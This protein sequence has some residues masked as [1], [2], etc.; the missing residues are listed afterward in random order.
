MSHLKGRGDGGAGEPGRVRAPA[1]GRRN[2]AD[3]QWMQKDTRRAEETRGRLAT[4]LLPGG[5]GAPPSGR[6]AIRV[7]SL[8]T[9]LWL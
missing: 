8:G 1:P 4:E 5:Q 2:P 7:R 6:R 9:L 3:F